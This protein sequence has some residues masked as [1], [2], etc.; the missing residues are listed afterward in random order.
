MSDQG[1]LERNFLRSARR[2]LSPSQADEARVHAAVTKLAAL[3][4]AAPTP[5]DA[6]GAVDAAVGVAGRW[7]SRLAVGAALVAGGGAAY[8]TGHVLVVAGGLAM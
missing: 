3:G 6:G 7:V 1:E 4:P 2:G 5:S 8:V